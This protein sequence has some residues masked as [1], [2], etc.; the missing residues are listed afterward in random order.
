MSIQQ[1]LQETDRTGLC[2]EQSADLKKQKQ[3]FKF[4]PPGEAIKLDS[5]L[6]L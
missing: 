6:L 3:F 5:D 4:L 1:T 2:T